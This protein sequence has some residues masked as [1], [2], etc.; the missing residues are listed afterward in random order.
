VPFRLEPELETLQARA[1]KL[2]A[3]LEPL[4]DEADGMSTLH[5]G[6]RD[7]LAASGLCRVVVPVAYG[8]AADRV[9]PLAVCVVREALM[10]VCSHADSLFALQG[11][12]SY[13]ITAG[14]SEEQRREW[15]P[16]VASLE[17]IAAFA[18]TEPDAGSDLKALTTTLVE[19][20]G[21]LVL[22]GCKSFISNAG[23]A[24]FYTTLARE[25][26]GFT[27]VLVPAD[28]PGVSV[29]PLP[30]LIAPHVIGDVVFDGVRLSPDAR[31]G[32]AG[33]GFELVLATLATFRVS[34]AGAAVGLAE[35][36]L[37][38]AVRH[39]RTRQQ[40]GRPLA[41]LGPVAGL[42][43]DSWADVEM[44]RLLT[45]AT[46]ERA[47]ENPLA[48]LDRSSLAKLAATEAASRVVDRCVQVMGRFSL[49]HGNKVEKL[50]RQ[51]RPMRIYEGASEVLRLGIA[52]RLT[53]DVE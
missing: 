53:K 44:A 27:V 38:E 45:Y 47:R 9:D 28:A 11:I 21:E 1:R 6:V 25:G 30:P 16:R 15:L 43:A 41:Q 31:I 35:A 32:E 26:D 12:G 48:E 23:A 17:T 33:K 39:T 50:Y 3:A 8:G 49:V 13:A 20:D 7:A 24:G 4:A 29:E 22:D 10:A 46:A 19:R 36:A 40:F 42:L 34:V 37:H 5:E 18:V 51:S 2:A 14:G 52:R